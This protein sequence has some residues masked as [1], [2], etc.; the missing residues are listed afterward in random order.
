M[1]DPMKIPEKRGHGR[2]RQLGYTLVEL[3]GVAS[4]LVFLVLATQGLTLNYRRFAL[5]ETAVQRLKQL[6][7]AEHTFRFMNDL[8]V[9]PQSTY[10]SF[11][12]LQNAK[13][14][15]AYYLDGSGNQHAVVDS[16]EKRHTVNA[17]V[18]YYK[19]N[20][21][22][23]TEEHFMP[24]REDEFYPP[25]ENGYLVRATPLPNPLGLKTF[26]MQEDGEIYWYRYG[27]P[28]L[29]MPR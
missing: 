12:D 27:L 28:W 17:F 6:A 21:V 3:L 10:G 23:N 5:E 18:P 20:F 24:G 8:S 22:Q 2:N 11:F 19:L 26:Y 14:I 1:V 16:D 7:R 13:L 25:D 9:N 15:P 4:I 29:F